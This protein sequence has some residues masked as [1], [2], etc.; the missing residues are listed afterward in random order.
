MLADLMNAFGLKQVTELQQELKD[1]APKLESAGDSMLKKR[2]QIKKLHEAKAGKSED[3]RSKDET[4]RE[5]RTE[6]QELQATTDSALVS[7]KEVMKGINEFRPLTY[8]PVTCLL[9]SVF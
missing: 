8:L 6:V 7:A 1:I 3:L 4:L 5:L 2:E 9:E